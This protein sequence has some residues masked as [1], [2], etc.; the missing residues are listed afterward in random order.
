MI[1]III[2]IIVILFYFYLIMT[3]FS[4]TSLFLNFILITA[5]YFLIRKNLKDKDNHKYYIVSLFLTALFFIFSYTTLIHD[6]IIL[7]K[8][9]LLSL[10]TYIVGLVYESYFYLKEKYKR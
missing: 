7:T 6:F 4:L 9:I 1:E 5:L 3:F 2:G 8:Q 10:V